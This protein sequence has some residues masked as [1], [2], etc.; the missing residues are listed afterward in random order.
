MDQR[1][2]GINGNLLLRVSGF[3]HATGNVRVK[4]NV[5]SSR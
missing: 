4:E 1:C 5:H 2:H 3:R